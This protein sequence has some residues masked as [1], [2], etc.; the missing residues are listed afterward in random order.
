M[1]YDIPRDAD[2]SRVYG[3]PEF[4]R[5]RLQR[6]PVPVRRAVE[7]AE[8]VVTPEEAQ[9][10]YRAAHARLNAQEPGHRPVARIVRQGAARK[11][12]GSMPPFWFRHDY[13]AQSPIFRERDWIILTR[14]TSWRDILAATSHV[15]GVKTVDITSERRTRNVVR[16]RQA[17]MYLMRELT[18]L[19]L[20]R[21]GKVIGDRDHST[22]SH[23]ISKI[24]ALLKN[25]DAEMAAEIAAIRKLLGAA[26]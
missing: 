13:S 22:I 17:A 10:R 8:A 20:P 19:S 16:P 5:A 7:A 25:G 18:P 21:I 1:L 24:A 12:A 15:Y 6:L 23:G 3:T 11:D 2:A 4:E 26:E 14:R 9:A